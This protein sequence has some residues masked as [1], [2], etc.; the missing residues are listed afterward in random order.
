MLD[1]SLQA[2]RSARQLIELLSQFWKM[3]YSPEVSQ[4]LALERYWRKARPEVGEPARSIC[5]P[6]GHAPPQQAG[7]NGSSQGRDEVN[8]LPVR[9][10]S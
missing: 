3:T 2:P 6:A 9:T 10:H 7:H 1:G 4:A 8:G 5:A